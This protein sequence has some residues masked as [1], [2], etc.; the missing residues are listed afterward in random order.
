[1]GEHRAPEVVDHQHLGRAAPGPEG[2]LLDGE[3]LFER[4]RQGELDVYR[5]TVAQ[6]QH[7]KAQPPPGRSDPEWT[8]IAPVDL[9]AFAGREAQRQEC[10]RP[11]RAHPADKLL[12]DGIAARVALL[13]QLLQQLPDAVGMLI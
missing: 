4:L 2:V 3:E 1:M 10:L 9:R 12:P 13:P 8:R 11:A 5:P 6:H 7:Q